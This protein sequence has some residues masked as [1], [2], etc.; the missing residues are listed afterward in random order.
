MWG[1]QPGQFGAAAAPVC[2]VGSGLKRSLAGHFA[3]CAPIAWPSTRAV[4]RR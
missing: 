3:T 4:R 1:R 2:E